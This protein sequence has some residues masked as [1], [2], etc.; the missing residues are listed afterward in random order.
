GIGTSMDLDFNNVEVNTEIPPIAEVFEYVHYD[1]KSTKIHS[2]IDS[3]T[4]VVNDTVIDQTDDWT[5]DHTLHFSIGTIQLN[6]VWEANYTL[7]VLKEGQIRIFDSASMIRF[8]NGQVVNLP[9]TY[10]TVLSEEGEPLTG[11][12]LHLM[13]LRVTTPD[14]ILEYAT[15][16]WDLSYTGTRE[17]Q[18]RI[19]ISTNGMTWEHVAD[20]PVLHCSGAGG[21]TVITQSTTL[22]LRG[23]EPTQYQVRV[24]AHADDAPDDHAEVILRI[25]E[26]VKTA[27]I[28][29]N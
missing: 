29:I 19:D 12:E 8:N 15:L 9:D 5:A 14:P 17:V 11:R 4:N 18:Q 25:S 7:K 22:D 3:E 13:G 1:L 24:T 20:M 26:L 23:F 2:Y 16:E 21:C 6:Q 10:L 27:K 28:R